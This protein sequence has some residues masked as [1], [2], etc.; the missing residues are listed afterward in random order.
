MKNESL[1]SYLL[2]R[3]TAKTAESYAREIE[4]Y[5]NGYAKADKAVYKD[6]T[7][8]LG[9]LRKR[10]S[11]AKTLNRLLCSIKAYYDFL[12]HTG[13]RKDNPARAI[14]LRDHI[15]RDIQL[16]DLFTE[17]ELESLLE[18]R[19]T[20]LTCRNRVLISLLIYQALLPTEIEGLTVNEINLSQGSI[21]I[22][23]SHK[24]NGRELPL[25]PCQIML[26]HVYIKEVRARL[27]KHPLEDSLL[28]GSRGGRVKAEDIT[29]QVKRIFKDHCPSRRVNAMTI[30]QSVIANLLKAGHD[31][32]IVQVF[33]GHKYPSTTERYKQTHVEALQAAILRYHPM[34]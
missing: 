8:Y 19:F 29:K 20:M 4:A 12:N 25:K 1:K 32:R 27:N 23:G 2:S 18:E 9:V 33:A 34:R 3:H 17:K 10:Y 31:V 15:S 11:N 14:R 5:R 6:I 21:Y 22:K 16:Q 28:I 24:T 13:K 30:R 26:L 7:G